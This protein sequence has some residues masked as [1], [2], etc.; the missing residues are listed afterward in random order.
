LGEND[1]LFSLAELSVGLAGFS[2]IVVLFKRRENG[3]WRARDA[4]RFHGM[5]LHAVSA[6][7][8]CVLPALVG[9]FAGAGDRLWTTVSFV[10][11][12]DLLWHTTI[13]FRM[14]ST[15]PKERPLVALGYLPGLLQLAVVFDLVA[16]ER[17]P[18][19]LV[20]VL[21]HVFLAGFL[22]VALIWIPDDD[23]ERG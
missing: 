16:L 7:F 5:V 15:L 4:D 2:A 3:K 18:T 11:G 17:F 13:V 10:L 1:L 20:G 23:V 12:V 19:Y 22:F 21:W 14:P 9:V 6:G 8:F